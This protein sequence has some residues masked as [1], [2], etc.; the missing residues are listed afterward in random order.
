MNIS[1]AVSLTESQYEMAWEGP[2]TQKGEPNMYTVPTRCEIMRTRWWR[3]GGSGERLQL[4]MLLFKL[5]P[6]TRS[7]KMSRI[8][9]LSIDYWV[10]CTCVCVIGLFAWNLMGTPRKKNQLCTRVVSPQGLF[11]ETLWPS[12]LFFTSCRWWTKEMMWES[13]SNKYPWDSTK[14][15]AINMGVTC[16][17]RLCPK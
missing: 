5:W 4:P 17:S 15:P 2:R 12:L 1:E 14:L 10:I 16:T 8:V 13:K 7:H 6:L 11:S 9:N 3:H